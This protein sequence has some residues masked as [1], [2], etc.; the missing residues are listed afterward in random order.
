MGRWVERDPIQFKGGDTN[1]YAYVGNDPVNKIDPKGESLI[2]VGATILCEAFNVYSYYQSKEA[3]NELM[4]ELNNQR[5]YINRLRGKQ[6]NATCSSED[7][8]FEIKI[9]QAEADFI[10][11]SKELT[12]KQGDF[13]KSSAIALMCLG[14]TQL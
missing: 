11:F 2:G 14:L 13:G 9:A 10:K 1:L 6:Q 3:I 5:D 7:M 8:N 4:N 12:S